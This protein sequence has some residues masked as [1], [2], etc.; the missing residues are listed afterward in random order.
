MVSKRVESEFDD[1]E[2]DTGADGGALVTVSAL[3]AIT[4]SEVAMQLDAAHRYPRSIQRF[5][6]EATSL[7][8][9]SEEIAE[10]C[11]YG[12]PRGGKIIEGKSIRLAEICASNWRNL[13]VAARVL[14]PDHENAV[15]Q[16][17]VWDL[18]QN[19]RLTVDAKRGILRSNG[20]RYD[21]DMIRVT[22][23]A[24]QSIALRNAVFRIIPGAYT[25]QIYREARSVAVGDAQTLVAKRDKWL[26]RLAKMGATA[27]RVF[28]RLQVIGANDITLD[29]LATLIGLAQSIRANELEVDKAFPPV[30]V[31]T[32][33]PAASAGQPAAAATPAAEAPEGR[34]V[35]VGQGKRAAAASAATP[36]A[37]SAPPKTT[38]N[39]A[40]S[41]AAAAREPTIG[42]D[43]RHPVAAAAAAP[44]ASAP[45]PDALGPTGE[46]G[47]GPHPVGVVGV[48]RKA[49][50][51]NLA[52]VDDAWK[53]APDARAIVDSWSEDER[54]AA[55]AWTHKVIS[56]APM[57][58][59]LKRPP[60]TNID[61]PPEDG[62]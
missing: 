44:N 9:Y 3:E 11:M 16:A 35:K 25:D 49:L 2:V 45:A 13:H 23:M 27:E 21:E 54:A 4:R 42:P 20:A 38:E 30:V 51:L 58:E 24:A 62:E 57:A 29:H 6:R 5:L 14:E 50:V 15:A 28:A 32:S 47:P 59:Q 39:P 53:T 48:D 18:Q 10:S 12:I 19:V 1:D 40:L 43:A 31:V 34:R 7:A 41:S 8:T 61:G 17:V 55:Y 46:R 52:L 56:N 36:N 60:F 33:A 37:S 26:E 22:G